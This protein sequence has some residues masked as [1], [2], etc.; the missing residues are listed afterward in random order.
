MVQE[1]PICDWLRENYW[2]SRERETNSGPLRLDTFDYLVGPFEAVEDP[3]VKN[4]TFVSATQVGK[5]IWL[6]AS[7]AYLA[8]QRP[9]PAIVCA[10]TE[11]TCVELRDRFY[12]NLLASPTL[13]SVV[14][15]KR[16]WNTRV[17]Q[18]GAP[19]YLAWAGSMTRLR[20]RPCRYGAITE[21]DV[22]RAPK[23]GPPARAIEERSKGYLLP[24]MLKES[25]LVGEGSE[26]LAEWKLG[27]RQSLWSQCPLCG[28]W[29]P[30]K[31]FAEREGEFA[32]RG[33]LAG[34][35]DENGEWKLEGDL[36]RDVHY[37]CLSGCSIPET[38]K[39][40]LVTGSVWVREGESV[41]DGRVI[42]TPTNPTESHRSFWSWSI[43]A[44]NLSF[45]EI[46]WQYQVH[47][48]TNELDAYFRD[49][50]A[51][52]RTTSRRMPTYQ[53]VGIHHA[54]AHLRGE[55]WPDAYFLT[56][57][58]DVQEDCCYYVVRAWGRGKCSWLVD[59]GCIRRYPEIEAGN[60]ELPYDLEQITQLVWGKTWPVAFGKQSPLGKSVMACKL[61]LID[62]QYS[63]RKGHV[64][65]AITRVLETPI[66]Y[67]NRVRAMLGD[68]R[69]KAAERWRRRELDVS[70]AGGLPAFWRVNVNIFKEENFE[71]IV[72]GNRQ[73]LLTQDIVGPAGGDY[74]R[75]IVNERFEQIRNKRTG[76]V[77]GHEWRMISH[78]IGNHYWDCEVGAN[79]AAEMVLA[80]NKLDWHG[81]EWIVPRE[82]PAESEYQRSLIERGRH[83]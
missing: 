76:Q 16:L 63:H 41:V 61:N 6:M 45:G 58:T 71:W 68:T 48:K 10:P 79:A 64:E 62:Y 23:T 2:L 77:T 50:L 26:I 66:G 56:S 29:Q 70:E 30:L 54:G 4:V 20:S 18:A 34:Y 65:S 57:M 73:W 9:A 28:R 37:A 3:L 69:I 27:D 12:G 31:F 47:D 33:G 83:D 82:R 11:P 22:C 75:Q 80:E 21:V 59:W 78:R 60:T 35:R 36:R 15:P 13:K 43:H 32:G 40:D 53:R 67:D 7:L 19:I 25:S 38:A 55:I 5:T 1:V 46:A 74:L 72:E 44:R 81:G 14:P 39:D 24:K 49:W 8:N 51:I 17:M 42:G 52:A